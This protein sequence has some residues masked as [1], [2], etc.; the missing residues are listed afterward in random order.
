MICEKCGKQY[1]D[2]AVKCPFCEEETAD[3]TAVVEEVTEPAAEEMDLENIGKS[4]KK[5]SKVAIWIASIV[6][7]LAAAIFALASYFGS[8]SNLIDSITNMVAGKTEH[9]SVYVVTKN[10]KNKVYVRVEEGEEY[11]VKTLVENEQFSEFSEFIVKNNKMYYYNDEGGLSLINMKNGKI[12]ILGDD[13]K[14]GTMAI[15]AK[16]DTILYSGEDG[17]L[18]KTSKDKKAVVVADIGESTFANGF[19]NYGFVEG[20]NN[21]WYTPVSA[22]EQAGTLYLESGDIIA[23]KVTSVFHVGDKGETVVYAEL[24]KEETIEPEIEETAEGEEAQQAEPVVL[25]TYALMLKEE[26]KKPVVLNDNFTD[27]DAVSVSIL[28]K[29]YKGVLYIADRGEAPTDP[30][31]GAVIGDALG[32]L[33]FREFGGEVKTLEK[34]VSVAVIF[35]EFYGS[36]KFYD[37]SDRPEDETIVYMKENT[38]SF[39]RDMKKVENPEEFEFLSSTPYLDH[40]N[41]FMLYKTYNPAPVVEESAEGEEEVATETKPVKLVYTKLVDGA[42]SKYTVIAEDVIDYNYD[43]ECETVY[44]LL[45]EKDDLN[46]LVLYAYNIADGKSKKIDEDVLPGYITLT[47]KGKNVYYV[48]NYNSE[49]QSASISLYSDGKASIAE[50]DIAGCLI[51]SDGTPY[52]TKTKGDSTFEFG[53]LDGGEF[54]LNNKNVSNILYAR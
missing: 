42:W 51:V 16:G 30:E 21:V 25:R 35:D 29:D 18:Y 41:T 11:A 45:N 27:N 12:T 33:Y 50:K 38:F 53:Y 49:T 15:S 17:T 26:G 34:D 47:D 32:T 13:L 7:V 31:T 44:Y 48:S 54:I 46:S 39:I 9:A 5:K 24:T 36:N 3:E 28:H 37:A 23:E 6:V 22:D 40:S 14:P 1:D 4:G 10:N 8:F 2:D 52:I 20:T 19:P 43:S